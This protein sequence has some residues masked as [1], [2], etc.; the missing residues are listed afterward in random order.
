MDFT[1]DSMA[2]FL[3]EMAVHMPMA[4]HN[5]LAAAAQVVETEA[6]AEIGHYQGAA[7]PFAA[8]APLKPETI[9]QKAN[10]D[11]PLLETGE[12][13]DSI[14]TVIQEHEAYVGSDDDKAVWQELGTS[15]GIPP[16]SFLGG[17][18]AR[19]SGE[20]RD[21]IGREMHAALVKAEA[22]QFAN[23]ARQVIDIP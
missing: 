10:G 21:I 19:K 9:A 8:W 13:R 1:L 22:P 17:A 23:G 20:V 15:R 12:M 18:A 2:A 6:K 7:G 4:E 16:R 5:A 3:T 14:G 11:T